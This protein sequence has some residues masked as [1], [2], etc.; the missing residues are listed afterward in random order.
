MLYLLKVSRTENLTQSREFI[1][2]QLSEFPQIM[3][4]DP[5]TW[6]RETAKF[7]VVFRNN[8]QSYPDPLVRDHFNK[9]L[10]G[11]FKQLREAS[12]LTPTGSDD[13]ASLADH[14]IMQFS[15]EA[16]KA[17]ELK[18]FNKKTLFLPLGEMV[19]K[20]PER[21]AVG[22]R[23]LNG[24]RLVILNV[25]HPIL[26]EWHEIILPKERKVWHK[27]GPARAV[28]DIVAGA[29]ESMQASEFP[30][31]D[32]D[33]L[34]GKGRKNKRAALSIGVDADGIEYMGE[35]E[36]NFPR[37]CAGRDTTQNQ[38]CL[39]SEGLYYTQDA[40]ETARSGHTRIENEY[41]ANKAIYG[42]DKMIIQ[43]ENLAKPRGLMRLIKA[44]VEGK[45]LSFDYLPLN[46]QFDLGTHSLFLAKRWS[47]KER[48]PVHLER[49]YYLLK[50]M[51]QVRLGELDIFDTLER[52]HTE[53]PFFDFNSEVKSP[54][55]VVRWK[56]RKLIKQL[57]REMAWQFKIPTGLDI[58]RHKGD[59]VPVKISL[60]GF[61]T[62]TKNIDFEKRWL[63]FL[64]RSSQR[65]KL[66]QSRELSPY[67]KVFNKGDSD[68]DGLGL[69]EDDWV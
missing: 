65:T 45:A 43:G 44:V 53:H 66:Y 3:E 29:P 67:E 34:V 57:D 42:I 51:G 23:M 27:G 25:K 48:F 49:M 19:K 55:Q 7:L 32:Y 52:A 33:A 10:E 24:E 12:V 56:S 18:E 2:N 39:G 16:A 61:V 5:N 28:L 26:N 8:L 30:W 64:G 31:N 21:F 50:Q 63:A 36:L 20:Q 11:L 4:G 17:F 60:D 9:H 1:R 22:A 58:E 47:K 38:V 37:Y 14:M 13:F 59:T 35:D 41:V 68:A 15:M 46:S 62:G 6:W 40:L 54:M 69:D